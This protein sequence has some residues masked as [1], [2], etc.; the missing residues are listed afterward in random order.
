VWVGGCMWVYLYIIVYISTYIYVCMYIYI[1]R[2]IYIHIHIHICM[3]VNMYTRMYTYTY[4]HICEL[5][6]DMTRPYARLTITFD[7]IKTWHS[8]P[9]QV[10]YVLTSSHVRYDSFIDAPN[11]SD[12]NINFFDLGPT[13][14]CQSFGIQIPKKSLSF[15]SFSMIQIYLYGMYLWNIS[16]YVRNCIRDCLKCTF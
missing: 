8:C 4:V 13:E 11:I 12:A 5:I 1:E 7:T 6:S 15:D 3:S 16:L 10:K 14:L 9:C 2:D